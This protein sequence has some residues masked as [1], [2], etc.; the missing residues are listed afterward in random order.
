MGIEYRAVIVVGLPHDKLM[1]QY[2]EEE[3]EELSNRIDC[4]D[5]DLFS[6]YFDAERDDCVVGFVVKQSDDYSYETVDMNE[7]L[8]KQAEAVRAWENAFPRIPYNTYLM[9]YGW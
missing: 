8:A 2:S 1:G 9:P 6:P 7:L 3:R 4:G 5:I